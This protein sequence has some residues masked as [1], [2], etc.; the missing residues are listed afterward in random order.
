VKSLYVGVA[1][2]EGQFLEGGLGTEALQLWVGHLFTTSD[3]HKLG[4]DTWSFNPRAI[5]VAKKVGFVC[6]GCQR[7]MQYWQGE[8]LDLL[9]FGMLRSEWESN[10]RMVK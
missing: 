2:C 4:A 6:E 3:I 1:I 10:R 9:N 7:A 5:R 8:W